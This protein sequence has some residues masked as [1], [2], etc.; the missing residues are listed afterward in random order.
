MVIPGTYSVTLKKDDDIAVTGVKVSADPRMAAP[1]TSAMRSNLERAE[2]FG[3]RINTLNEKLQKIT[4]V[5]ESLA[6]S[7]ELMVRDSS[8]AKAMAP[9][10]KTVKEELAKLDEA[11]GRSQDGLISRINGYRSLL[12][13]S[14]VPAPQEEKVM[15]DATA[16]V[17]EAEK[18]INGFLDGIW[19]SYS[20]AL[21]GVSLTGN[22]V[23]LR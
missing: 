11:F 16:A 22:T 18:L 10:Q 12:M 6:K 20:N 21:K 15:T 19:A 7:D 13:A 3:L 1:D 14:G 2:A 23:I 4:S 8:F 5:R 9:I 17:E